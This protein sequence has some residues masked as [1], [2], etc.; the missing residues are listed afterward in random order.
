M[1]LNDDQVKLELKENVGDPL[2]AEKVAERNW[3]KEGFRNHDWWYFFGGE[4]GPH[5]NCLKVLGI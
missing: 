2:E 4:L 5:R 3:R 1:H